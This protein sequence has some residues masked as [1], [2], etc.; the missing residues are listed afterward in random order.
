[1]IKKL[2]ARWSS[3]TMVLSAIVGAPCFL[4]ILLVPIGLGAVAASSV[5]VF[6][7]QYRF[8]FMALAIG[9]L[10]LSHWGLRKA[11][12]FRPTKLVW[13]LTIVTAGM[14]IAELIIHPIGK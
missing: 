9:L 8:I 2:N 4:G 11:E 1:M 12:V 13:I 7:D 3:V 6:F 10:V 14:I 5:F